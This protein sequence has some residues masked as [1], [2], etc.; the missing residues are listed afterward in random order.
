MIRRIA[1]AFALLSLGLAPTREDLGPFTATSDVG[2]P[3]KAG[4]AF[5][6]AGTQTFRVSGAGKNMWAQRDEFRFVW[7]ELSGDFIIQARASFEGQGTDPHRKLGLIARKNREPGSPYA[8]AAVHGDG[9][10]SLQYRREAD[11]PTQEAKS[12]LQ[13]ADVIQLARKGRSLTMSVAK[14]GDTFTGTT[15]DD[16]DLGDRLLVGLFVCAHNP[17]VVE[18]AVFR[19]VRVILPA[20]ANLRPYREFLGSNLETLDVTSGDRR[21]LHRTPGSIQAPNWTPD[22]KAL[23]YNADGHL[24]RFDLATRKPT[25]IDTGAVDRNNN[26]HAISFDGRTL[27][28][29]SSSPESDGKSLIYTVPVEGGMPRKVTERGP[30]YLHGWSPDGKT[31]AFTGQRDGEFDVYTIPAAGGDETR[32]TTA[33]GLDDGPE[34]TPDGS[35]IY[36][37]SNRTGRMQLWRMKPDGSGQEQLTDDGFNDWFPHIS[38][39]GKKI[40]FLSFGPEVDPGDHP[41]YKPVY[42]RMMPISGGPPKVVAYVYGGQGTINVPSWSPDS[43]SAA[44]I[45]NTGPPGR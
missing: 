17:D 20:P 43:R 36:F 24:F 7:A 28:I 4:A 41:F 16:L 13:G 2:D 29:S 25:R 21:I 35:R 19:D 18:T 22:G 39:D 3:A 11:G 38:P 30:S 6:D 34:Y 42:L 45:S 14:F 8:D 33:K 32:L 5:Y 44:F 12:S 1:A 31:L 10:V 9:L 15:V 26:D 23:I 27:A 40:L 37:N